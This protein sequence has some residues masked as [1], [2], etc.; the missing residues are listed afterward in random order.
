[1]SQHLCPKKCGKAFETKALLRRHLKRKNDCRIGKAQCPDCELPFS[2]KKAVKA[3]LKLG[4]CKGKQ[5]AFI[6]QQLAAENMQQKKRLEASELQHETLLE[7]CEDMEVEYYAIKKAYA[8]LKQEHSQQQAELKMLHAS[9]DHIS[10][11]LARVQIK[12]GINGFDDAFVRR[13]F[14]YSLEHLHEKGPG[15]VKQ[16]KQ[17]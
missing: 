10:E 2:D 6:A 5:P 1:M 17:Y 16:Q 7:K 12:L 3:H 15:C 8:A 14:M 11:E 4:R 9:H 13:Q